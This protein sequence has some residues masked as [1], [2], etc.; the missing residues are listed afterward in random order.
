[1]Q[2]APCLSSW[3]RAA[4]TMVTYDLVAEAANWISSTRDHVNDIQANP[5]AATMLTSAVPVGREQADPERS[6]RLSF[7]PRHPQ[8]ASSDRPQPEHDADQ[9]NEH[10][11]YH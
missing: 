8:F 6:R 11:G 5:A 3:A 9:R 10:S 1:M 4:S 7:A 2:T